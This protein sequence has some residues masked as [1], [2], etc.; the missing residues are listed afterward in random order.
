MSE[1][2]Q[3]IEKIEKLCGILQ[4]HGIIHS[5][6]PLRELIRGLKKTRVERGLKYQ[7]IDLT[8]HNLSG[9]Q[10]INDDK[11]DSA[12]FDVKLHLNIALLPGL[13]F[14]FGSVRSSVVEITYE[15][16][17]E[18]TCNL[19]RGAWHLDFHEDDTPEFI[20]PS[21][22]FH[23]G[24]R[25]IKESTED[26]GELVLLDAP[27]LMHPPLDLFLAVDLLASNFLK[28]RVWRNL[29]ADTSYQELVKESQ[30][31]WWMDYYQQ[32]ADYWKHQ[33]SGK[34]DVNK[35]HA[36]QLAIPYLYV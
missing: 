23:H 26:Y 8:F 25:R 33:T 1:K 31:K 3:V 36:A 18:V 35:R 14:R 19:A 17:S 4:I 10:F 5:D 24:G 21:Y 15:A 28:D 30:S 32:I 16:Y 29:R 34:V 12:S 7:L 2:E 6:E 9:K 13:E 27:R 11:W 22:H 20:H